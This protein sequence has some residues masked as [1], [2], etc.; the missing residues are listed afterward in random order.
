MKKIYSALLALLLLASFPALAQK[1]MYFG[2]A[3]TFQNVW[4]T[5]QNNYGMIFMDYQKTFGAAGNLTVGYDFNNHVGI[6]I[7]VGY[8]QFGQKYTD[9]LGDSALSRQVKLNYLEIPIMFKYTS[10]GAVARF[11]FA[12]GPQINMLL[13]ATQTYTMNGAAYDTIRTTVSGVKFNVSNES[14]KERWSSMDVMARLDLG[15]DITLVKHL[16]LEVGLKMGYG[17]MDL[18]STDYRIK[19][20]DGNINPSHNVFGG[21]SVGLTYHL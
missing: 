13:S 2:V 1:G 11:Y 14:I 18:N 7:E 15:V 19:D 4:I 16:I 3:G 17:L 21:L 10:G 12:V 8:G 9:H 6:K 5:S 20:H